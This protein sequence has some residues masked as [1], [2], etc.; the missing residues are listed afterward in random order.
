MEVWDFVDRKQKQ[1]GDET[2]EGQLDQKKTQERPTPL[3]V[4]RMKKA[5]DRPKHQVV[6]SN[7]QELNRPQESVHCATR[8]SPAQRLGSTTPG[9]CASDCKCAGVAGFV[10]VRSLGLSRRTLITETTLLPTAGS[11]NN[12][13]LELLIE[14]Q[15]AVANQEHKL[16]LRNNCP[17]EKLHVGVSVVAPKGIASRKLAG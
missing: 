4:L 13:G 16:A 9:P 2:V 5:I 17:N 7:Q 14:P 3:C 10:A 8:F 1:S 15:G 6:S 11:I 12:C